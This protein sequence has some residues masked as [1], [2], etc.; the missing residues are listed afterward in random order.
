MEKSAITRMENLAENIELFDAAKFCALFGADVDAHLLSNPRLN[1]L[2]SH[3]DCVLKLPEE[4]DLLAFS[5]SCAHEMFACGSSRNIVA[6]QSHPEFGVHVEYCIRDR[7]WPAV[8]DKSRRLGEDS[9][10][11]ARNSI[12]RFSCEDSEKLLKMVSQFLHNS[13]RSNPVTTTTL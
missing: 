10:S 8:V 4:S 11:K 2:A 13:L 6:C 7:I 1:L 12:D 9:I 5:S 3:G